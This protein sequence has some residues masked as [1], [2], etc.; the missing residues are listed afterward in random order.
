MRATVGAGLYTVEV[1]NGLEAAWEQV[2]DEVWG[3]PRV[4]S[5]EA[6]AMACGLEMLVDLKHHAVQ[7]RMERGPGQHPFVKAVQTMV[8]HWDEASDYPVSDWKYEVQ[9]DDTRLG[10]REWVENERAM[11]ALDERLALGD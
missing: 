4:W 2:E 5:D 9:N 6:E 7:V 3:G 11:K 1:W 10:Y 8:S